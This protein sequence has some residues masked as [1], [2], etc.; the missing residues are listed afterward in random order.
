MASMSSR[1][2]FCASSPV[3]RLQTCRPGAAQAVPERRAV[4]TRSLGSD[5][6]SPHIIERWVVAPYWLCMRAGATSC[7]FRHPVARPR[8]ECGTVQTSAQ[9]HSVT[10]SCRVDMHCTIPCSNSE[11]QKLWLP[12]RSVFCLVVGDSHMS[13]LWPGSARLSVIYH[14]RTHIQAVSHV[15]KRPCSTGPIR[16]CRQWPCSLRAVT[17]H[18][19]KLV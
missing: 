1:L 5:G 11:Q 12:V 13:D 15:G 8:A 9:S 6:A 19:G 7:T 16:H 10:E 2:P 14:G 18:V 4:L 3:R 17:S